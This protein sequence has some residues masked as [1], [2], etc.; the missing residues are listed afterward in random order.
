MGVRGVK[1]RAILF[2][3]NILQSA[4]PSPSAAHFLSNDSA[5]SS[6]PLPSFTSL[7]SAD[8]LGEE[9]E[10]SPPPRSKGKKNWF[11]CGKAED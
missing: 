8:P 11:L 3:I 4:S 9:Y 2:Y 10:A 7:P 5:P 1:R 6:Y